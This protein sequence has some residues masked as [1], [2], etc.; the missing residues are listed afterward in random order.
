MIPRNFGLPAR[1]WGILKQNFRSR[2]L[3]NSLVNIN[4]QYLAELSMFYHI[5]RSNKYDI[6]IRYQIIK[7]I[8]SISSLQSIDIGI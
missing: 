5:Y 2:N 7:F 4:R 8:S 1:I 3:I 6:I